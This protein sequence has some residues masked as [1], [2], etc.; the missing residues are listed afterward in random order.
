MGA[1]AEN[2]RRHCPLLLYHMQGRYRTAVV[3]GGDGVI[4]VQW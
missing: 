4:A 2:G 3:D 1:A